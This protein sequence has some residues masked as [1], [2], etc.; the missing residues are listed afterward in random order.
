MAAP[1]RSRAVGLTALVLLTAATLACRGTTST[2]T[3]GGAASASASVAITAGTS[4]TEGATPTAT[5][6]PTP[7]ATATPSPSPS[8][9]PAP[10]VTSPVIGYYLI[11]LGKVDAPA[12]SIL[13]GVDNAGMV[14]GDSFRW[15]AGF[16]KTVRPAPGQHLARVMRI[17]SSGA[18]AGDGCPTDYCH[19]TSWANPAAGRDLGTLGGHVSVAYDISDSGIV[20]GW[21]DTPGSNPTQTRAFKQSGTGAMIDLNTVVTSGPAMTLREA[22]GINSSNVIV[23]WAGTNAAP[24]AFQLTAVG[25]LTE[26]GPLPAMSTATAGAINDHGHITGYSG[27]GTDL[28]GFLYKS[29]AISALPFLAGYQLTH[30]YSINESD[31]VVG[32]GRNMADD[33]KVHAFVYTAGAIHDLNEYLRAGSGWTLE[34]ATGINDGGWIVGT[35]VYASNYHAFLLIPA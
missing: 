3:P 18:M 19:A 2:P 32:C 12:E 1:I 8:P 23:G 21:S 22:W 13:I 9:T 20:V 7:T 14:A 6:A 35:G 24:R 29:G 17:N 25:K 16:K 33:S 26:I 27:N 4:P 5:A 11:D 10:T 31:Q 28:R 15:L 30:P 34:C